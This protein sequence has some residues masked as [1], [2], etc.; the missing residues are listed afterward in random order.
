[1]TGSTL[2]ALRN[3]NL[4]TTECYSVVIEPYISSKAC[5]HLPTFDVTREASLK[6]SAPPA[7][8]VV[9]FFAKYSSDA[10]TGEQSFTWTAENPVSGVL[11]DVSFNKGKSKLVFKL[12]INGVAYVAKRLLQYSLEG[13]SKV[14][15]LANRDQ[16]TKEGITLGRTNF[17][18]KNFK[19]E[20]DSE[21]IEISAFD[22]TD[23]ALVR[24][25]TVNST[26]S[27]IPSPASGLAPSEYSDLLEAEKAELAADSNILSSITWLIERERGDVQLR[28]YS[29]TLDHPSYSDKQG[30][31]INLFQ[32]Y[33]YLFSRKTLVL[34]DIQAS[35]SHD[36]HSH[37]SILFDL[38]SHTING[39]SGAGDH[40][41]QGIKSFV[42]QH[43][44]V[45]KCAQMGLEALREREDGESE[46]EEGTSG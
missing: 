29:G 22:V 9:F 32:H 41:E 23:F 21:G 19:Q 27:F 11:T 10:K 26:E 45:Q 15:I 14:S 43:N 16:L 42:D 33:V 25:G 4:A 20:C 35:E 2:A 7:T 13:E 6:I 24:E 40:G 31:T 28:K 1:M 18:L 12:T 30:A 17:L 44:C 39:E 38:M 8:Q 34:A 37:T 5:D 36:K 3:N 46:D